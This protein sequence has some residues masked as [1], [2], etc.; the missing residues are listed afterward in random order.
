MNNAPAP[1]F[2]GFKPPTTDF[3]AVIDGRRSP[4][5]IYEVDLSSARSY[6]AG[7]AEQIRLTGNS[8]YIDQAPDVGNAYVVFEGVQ[9]NTGP[10]I[11]P[12]IYVQPG[13]VSRVPFANLW[14]ANSAQA[15]KKLRIIYGT[16]ID[17]L[18]SLNG[19]ISISGN[20]NSV[21]IGSTPTGFYSSVT[22]LA[23]LGTATVFAPAANT[24]GA[25][26]HNAQLAT[27]AGAGNRA[28]LIARNG[29]PANL[30]D[31]N[32]VLYANSIGSAN[33]FVASLDEPIN[34]AAGLGLYFISELLETNGHK[35]VHYSL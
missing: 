4:P 5:L 15:G 27:F 35:L 1:D 31:G 10:L 34:I 26:I 9:D 20:V 2:P 33:A 18:P 12:A 28:A 19:Q 8:F 24:A 14:I 3:G 6:G 32:V 22:N 11:R 16:D 29:A 7:T 25:R 30:T 13:F 23:A 21:N 17:F